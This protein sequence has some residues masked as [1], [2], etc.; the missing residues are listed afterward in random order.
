VP[1]RITFQLDVGRF[2]EMK[3]R[4]LFHS[5][6][7]IT[8]WVRPETSPMIPMIPD[9]LMLVTRNRTENVCR[10]SLVGFSGSRVM[11]TSEL[12]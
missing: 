3:V 1:L 11:P 9:G 10:W 2:N 12:P 5:T 6:V 4:V 8:A 7:E